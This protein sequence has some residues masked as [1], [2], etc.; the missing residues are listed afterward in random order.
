MSEDYNFCKYMIDNCKNQWKVNA[1]AY[2]HKTDLDY[3]I[4]ETRSTGGYWI[5]NNNKIRSTDK[6]GFE[7]NYISRLGP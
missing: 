3:V 5:P 4:L 1:H 7:K 6:T 2:S